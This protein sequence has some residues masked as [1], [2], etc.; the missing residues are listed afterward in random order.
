MKDITLFQASSRLH[1]AAEADKKAIIYITDFISSINE[2]LS[3]KLPAILANHFNFPYVITAHFGE[4]QSFEEFGSFGFDDKNDALFLIMK[5]FLKNQHEVRSSEVQTSLNSPRLGFIHS[6]ILIPAKSRHSIVGFIFMGDA[7]PRKEINLSMDTFLAVSH[8]Y[9]QELARRKL[10]N[11]LQQSYLELNTIFKSLGQGL[12]M[13]DVYGVISGHHSDSALDHFGCDPSHQR[14]SKVLQLNKDAEQGVEIWLKTM[15]KKLLS[16][17][18]LIP[19]GPKSFEKNEDRYIE[20]KYR[21]IY[22]GSGDLKSI[23]IISTDKTQERILAREA[24]ERSMLAEIV[25]TILNDRHTFRRF[26]KDTRHILKQLSGGF[27]DLDIDEV[28]RQLHTLK[29]NCGLFKLTEM[30]D[31]IHQTESVTTRLS[32]QGK[33]EISIRHHIKEQLTKIE[34]SFSHSFNRLKQILGQLI[35]P[36][37][38]IRE[39]PK[40]KILL[41]S[42]LLLGHL[43]Q[44]SD[45]FMKFIDDFLLDNIHIHFH[46]FIQLVEEQALNLEKNATLTVHESNIRINADIYLPL[47]SSFIHVFRNAIDHGIENPESRVAANKESTGHIEVS[48]DTL[49]DGNTLLIL[50]KDDGSGMDPEV[51]ADKAEEKGIINATERVT[52]DTHTI[53]Q[54]TTSP[55][56]TTCK[57]VT[58]LSGRGVGLDALRYEAERI[59]GQVTVYSELGEGTSV[60]VKVPL[61]TWT[62]DA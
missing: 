18:D 50:V 17:E 31:I 20:L 58:E 33:P 39:I 60:E 34:Q 45:I 56:F 49:D 26:I 37:E 57:R 12:M 28:S 10:E 19:L 51:I 32:N 55:L 43:G 62:V 9:G 13:C 5:D 14:L 7:V 25:M 24:K 23:L 61:L 41:M 16:F 53:L 54:L 35:D 46:K 11:Q 4:N 30:S 36:D 15:F 48:F 27:N 2:G 38:E 3:E 52:L 59:K 42:K 21:P 22:D 8:F 6:F 44:Q 1:R 47:F 40:E 29:G